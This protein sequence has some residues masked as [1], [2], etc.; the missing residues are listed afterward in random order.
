MEHYTQTWLEIPVEIEKILDITDPVITF[1]EVFNHIDPIKYFAGRGCR[2]GRPRYDLIK[3]L[4]VVLFAY[5]ENSKISLRAIEQKCKTDIRYM[6]LLERYPA[7]SHMTIANFINDI[8]SETIENI[9]VDINAYIFEKDHVDRSKVYI[10]DLQVP[11][12][13]D[14]RIE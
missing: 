1:N 2:E 14:S 8:L 10:E 9:F 7:P 12:R 13:I 3:L 5:M 4:K 11:D 6:W